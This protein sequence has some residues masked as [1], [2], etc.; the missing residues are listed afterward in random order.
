MFAPVHYAAQ[1]GHAWI[2]DE[3]AVR[4][5]KLM[6]AWYDDCGRVVRYN[7]VPGEGVEEVEIAIE[8]CW[9]NER[10]VW[11]DAEIGPDYDEDGICGPPYRMPVAQDGE[12][13][14]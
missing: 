8:F 1:V 4:S 7:R 5:G 13:T 9:V 3:E 2:I 10:S 12:E 11:C 6:I 14:R